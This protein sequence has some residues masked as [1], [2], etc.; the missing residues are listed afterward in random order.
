MLSCA[1]I[2]LSN[3]NNKNLISPFINLS[4]IYNRIFYFYKFFEIYRFGNCF[5]T[6]LFGET[7][8]FVS[9][10]ESAK[11]VLSNES[12][13]FTKKYIRSIGELVGTQSLLCASHQHHKMLRSH[14]NPLLSTSSLSNF[15][16]QFDELIVESLSEWK[17]R[18]CIILLDEALKVSLYFCFLLLI[19]ECIYF[20]L[21]Q[22]IYHYYLSQEL[23]PF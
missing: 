14:L 15:V 9:S 3:L 12:G 20:F 6:N 22:N 4:F 8:V 13:K 19:D 7:H 11:K 21:F 23:S 1:W 18:D 16:I 10:T 5:K 17:H 2:A